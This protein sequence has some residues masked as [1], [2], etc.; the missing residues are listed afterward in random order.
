MDTL[1]VDIDALEAG[2]ELDALICKRV[3]AQ[4]VRPNGSGGYEMGVVYA[5]EGDPVIVD[6]HW[7]PLSCFSADIAAAWLVVDH[8]RATHMLDLTDHITYWYARF[9]VLYGQGEPMI[10]GRTACV[11]IC[12][13]ALAALSR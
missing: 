2:P 8:M 1:D 6:I 9:V 13:A 7:H 10:K 11:A 12:K 4:P 5:D 3:M